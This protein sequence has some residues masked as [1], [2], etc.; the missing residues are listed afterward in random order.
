[1]PSLKNKVNFTKGWPSK[2]IVEESLRPDTGVTIEAGFI[3]VRK[4]SD[5]DVWVLGV[6]DL[7]DEPFVFRNDSDDPDANR[8]AHDAAE[9]KQVPFGGVQGISFQ[10]PLEIETIQFTG[11]PA[12]GERLYADTDGK[13][14]VGA[15]A[16]GTTVQAGKV[17]VAV[18]TKPLYYVGQAG[19][20][21]VVPCQRYTTV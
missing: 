14:K 5:P 9:Y 15:G 12:V 16:T 6:L 8:P 11:T 10:N 7:V 3:G 17:I 21:R 2:T 4:H 1:M 19:Y 20:I 13:L 18:V